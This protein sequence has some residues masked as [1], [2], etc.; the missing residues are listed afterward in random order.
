MEHEEV[1][2]VLVF[3]HWI[4]NK[5]FKLKNSNAVPELPR[6]FVSFI[7][8]AIEV[9]TPFRRTVKVLP[10]PPTP[11]AEDNTICIFLIK[12]VLL[13]F[14]WQNLSVLDASENPIKL[15]LLI[16]P[17]LIKFNGVDGILK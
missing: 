13:K 14:I 6:V 8:T 5:S 11:G 3:T 12:Q 1:A 4:L 16:F 9:F 7:V 15:L 17:P 10:V 2:G